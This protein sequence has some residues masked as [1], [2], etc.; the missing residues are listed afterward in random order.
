MI[1]AVCALF[2]RESAPLSIENCAVL[3]SIRRDFGAGDA[4]IDRK[5]CAIIIGSRW[6]S[7]RR[8]LDQDFDR[9]V[10]SA[11]KTHKILDENRTIL[12]W[13]LQVF[14]VLHA[15]WEFFSQTGM[16]FVVLQMT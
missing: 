14:G 3:R 8:G 15:R 1:F 11:R 12:R 7:F 5:T 6:T 13:F 16:V 9:A 4:R 10:R 2:L